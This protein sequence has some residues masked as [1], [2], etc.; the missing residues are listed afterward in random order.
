MKQNSDK[1]T[2][3]IRCAPM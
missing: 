1:C 3:L 2:C